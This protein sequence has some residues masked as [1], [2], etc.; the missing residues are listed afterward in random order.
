MDDRMTFTRSYSVVSRYWRLFVGVGLAAFVLSA[1]F[2]GSRFLK[3]R[4]KSQA[5]VYPGMPCSP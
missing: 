1:V 5:V 2:S 3:P 4:F